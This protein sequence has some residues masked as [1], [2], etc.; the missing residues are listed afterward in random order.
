MVDTR[1]KDRNL[2]NGTVAAGRVA[3]VLLAVATSDGDVGVTEL[4]R[5]LDIS[6]AVTYRI[7]RSRATR[8]LVVSRP[9]G[10]YGFGPAAAVLGARALQ[11]LD[12]RASA[13]PFLRRLQEET[14][15]TT[16]IS[17]LVGTSRVYLDQVVSLNE[18]KMSVDLGRGYPLYAGST[19]KSI[20]AVAPSDLRKQVLSRPLVAITDAT[21]SNRE[22]L[23]REL[24]RVTAEG[25]AA[26]RG[27]RQAGAGSVAAPVFAM[28]NLVVGAISVCGPIDRFGP[29][30]IERYK[31]LVR[32][33]ARALSDTLGSTRAGTATG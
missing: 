31:P 30:E 5:S 9:Q 2:S 19:G 29:E 12:L 24:E 13:L 15:E 14:G 28:Q 6:K 1:G 10:T 33:A 32:D 7:L 11:D 4:A 17:A 16:T 21:I 8:G 26:S 23:E 3:D 18:V 20:L 25:V 22:T 27:E